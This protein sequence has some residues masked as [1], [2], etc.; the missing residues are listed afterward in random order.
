MGITRAAACA[1]LLATLLL[2]PVRIEAASRHYVQGLAAAT[3]YDVYRNSTLVL[4]GLTSTE[5]GTLSFETG[6]SGTIQVVSAGSAPDIIPP[7]PVTSLAI[8]MGTTSAQLSWTAVGDDGLVGRATTYDLRWSSSPITLANWASATQVNGEPLPKTS[9]QSEVMTVG[10][11]TAGTTYYFAL[12]VGDEVPNWSALSNGVSGTTSG[13]GDTTPPNAVTNL[14][15]SSPTTSSITLTWTAVGDDGGSGQASIYD[16]RYATSPITSAN[17]GIATQ[18][19]GEPS[20]KTAGQSESFTVSGLASGTNY[21]FALKV[22]DETLNWSAI[23]NV[24]SGL[25]TSGGDTTPP[26]AVTNLAAGSA[27]TSSLTLTWTSVGDDGTSGKATTY[28]IRYGVSPITSGNWA[29]APQASG[30]PAPKTAGQAETF[31]VTGL[32]PGATYYFAMKVGDEVPNWSALSNVP[33]GTTLPGADT[34]APAAVTNLAVSTSAQTTATLSWTAVGDDG[35][36]GRATTYDIRYGVNPITTSNWNSAPQATGEPSPKTSGQ[37]ESFTVTG[38]SAGTTY[39]FA[40]KVADEVPNWSGLSNLATGA[41]LPGTDTTPPATVNTLTAS[42]FTTSSVML[43][44]VATG[45]DGNSGRATTYDLRYATTTINSSNWNTATRATGEPTPKQSGQNESF[46]LT[47]LAPDT[48]Y[49]FALK[50]GDEVPNW[51]G[52]SNI[53]TG[54]TLSNDTTAPGRVTNLTVLTTNASSASLRWTSV[55]DDGNSGQATRYDLRYYTAPITGSNWDDCEQVTGEP[56]PKTSGQ[57]ENFTVNGL[58]ANV[59]YYFALRVGDEVPNWGEISNS[60]SGVTGSGGGADTTPPGRIGNLVVNSTTSS[61]ATLGWISVGDDGQSGQATR[62]DIRFYSQPITTSNWNSCTHCSGEPT[63]KP[64]G[65]AEAFTVTGLNPNSTYYFAVKAGD[66]VPNYGDLSN[67][68]SGTTLLPV[69]VT[70]PDPVQDLS[71]SNLRP[72]GAALSWTAPGDDGNEGTAHHFDLR[73]SPSPITDG[74]WASATQLTGEPTPDAP[75]STA[76]MDLTGLQPETRYYFALKTFDEAGNGS[77]LSNLLNLLTPADADTLP[78]MIIRSLAFDG[79]LQD[80]FDLRWPAPSDTIETNDAVTGYEVILHTV[81]IVRHDQDGRRLLPGPQTPRNPGQ[82]ELYTVGGLS[83]NTT[84]YCR[85][86][87]R[88]GAGNWSNLSNQILVTTSPGTPPAEGDTIPPAVVTDLNASGVG[89]DWVELTW[90]AP[91]DNGPSGRASTYDIRHATF[92]ITSATWDIATSVAAPPTPG[93]PGATQTFVIDGLNVDILHYFALRATD[94]SHNESPT[95][96]VAQARTVR[97]LDVAPPHGTTDL[98]VADVA[99]ST[100]TLVWT[101]PADSITPYAQGSP[102]VTGYEMRVD[103]NSPSPFEWSAAQVLAP[104]TP[105]APGLIASL[106]IEGLSP[107]STYRFALRSRDVAGNWSQV[108]SVAEATTDTIVVEPPPPPPPPPADSLAPGLAQNFEFE[109]ST[110]TTGTLSWLSTGDDG[111]QGVATGY[112][113]RRRVALDEAGLGG[114]GFDWESS[115]SVW[116]PNDPLAAGTPDVLPQTGLTPGSFYVYGL[117]AYDEE[118][119]RGPVAWTIPAA[120]PWPDDNL[121]PDPVTDL[122]AEL[123]PA[124]TTQ[125]RWTA[126]LHWTAPPDQRPLRASNPVDHYLIRRAPVESAAFDWATA[127]FESTLTNP[128]AP[129]SVEQLDAFRVLA[130]ETWSFAVVSVDGDGNASR[131]SNVVSVAAAPDTGDGDPPPPPPPPA[132]ETAP[133]AITDLTGFATGPYSVQIEWTATGDDS[134]LGRASRYDL[135]WSRSAITDSTWADLDTLPI[136]PPDTVGAVQSYGW[137]GLAPGTHYFFALR[138]FDE[139]G[140]GSPLSNVADV[141]TVDDQD[142]SPPAVPTGLAATW[143]A[144]NVELSWQPSPDV[145]L[146]SYDVYRRR[147]DQQEAESVASGVTDATWRDTSAA[148]GK[149]Y[150][151]SVSARDA[152]GNAS[153][154]GREAMIAVPE[155]ST[156]LPPQIVVTV[157]LLDVE[158]PDPALDRAGLRWSTRANDELL[159]FNV[160]RE[161]ITGGVSARVSGGSLLPSPQGETTSASSHAGGPISLGAASPIDRTDWTLLTATPLLGPGPHEFVEHPLPAPGDYRYWIEALG[162]SGG[163]LLLP[164]ID[165]HVPN[166]TTEVFGV[167]PNPT[168][169]P[170]RVVFANDAEE[171]VS[172]RIY[173]A[174][175]RLVDVPL[176]QSLAAGRHEQDLDLGDAIGSDHPAG[177]YYAVLSMGRRQERMRIVLVTAK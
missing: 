126:R 34:V 95:S 38:L 11:L 28:D 143:H 118:G 172:L 175:G 53:P 98:T 147:S 82:M 113:L 31:T 132:D 80:R 156:P 25:T 57:T 51:S 139:A 33:T 5:N 30:E 120:M 24:P 79:V 107:A 15:T 68:P 176:E 4:G 48:R 50:V 114:P 99:E 12:K 3:T 54:R 8:V 100:L 177:V 137:G 155:D 174:A 65:Q 93:T 39:Y 55:G 121:A 135:R 162:K 159:G 87:S 76:T 49:Y 71:S 170:L 90:H 23:S 117:S 124:D 41:T 145:D 64:A 10:G 105:L 97:P 75:G 169:G 109:P 66:E 131:L 44:W 70:G 32:N 106:T 29:S 163:S 21:Y 128:K 2:I 141:R 130:G 138:V 35:T 52:L 9:G 160:Y 92:P 26:S 148:H 60:P 115:D 72:R 19:S 108:S 58:A 67:A 37:T 122:S 96:N 104:P 171:L 119:N 77:P 42:T 16:V 123:M 40:M 134:L 142:L 59:T 94:A 166:W 101:T 17:F 27:T 56:A 127:P 103:V 20:P 46:L 102:Q 36:T 7:A 154:R 168:T 84:Y 149:T 153:A 165:I 91:S 45:D 151:Y 140:N 86:R 81:P 173:D 78:P 73:R 22:A 85:I 112:Q 47:G 43:A 129:G 83:P 88:D 167:W 144:P 146:A 61:S 111:D 136:S 150:Y 18:A 69:D 164:P 158:A 116:I 152:A 161:P 110:P 63:P 89:P 157:D 6:A 74:N 1:C 13:G 125:G 133:A 62:Y 14:A